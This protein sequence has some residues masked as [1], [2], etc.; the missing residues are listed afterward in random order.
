MLILNMAEKIEKLVVS[1]LKYGFVGLFV[2]TALYF[3]LGVRSLN[4]AGNS[5]EPHYSNRDSVWTIRR[6]AKYD[7]CDVVVLEG[8]KIDS[9]QDK[10]IKRIIGIPGDKIEISNGKITINGQIVNE[11]GF[12][13]TSAHDTDNISLLL[14]SNE[15]FLLG[16]NRLDSNDSR[17][18]GV[19][20][21][22]YFSK[23]LKNNGKEACLKAYIGMSEKND[24]YSTKKQLNLVLVTLIIL[25]S[26]VLVA[27]FRKYIKKIFNTK[28]L[29]TI[30]KITVSTIVLYLTILLS[31]SVLIKLLWFFKLTPAQ[32]NWGN[33]NQIINDGENQFNRYDK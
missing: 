20:G 32:N 24:L 33:V 12:I 14:R 17:G 3:L 25:I 26:T 6:F 27:T 31:L 5:M 1:V 18:F 8:E 16:D 19:L 30:A 28:T 2:L 15:Y 22:N 11:N 10:L 21:K 23:V 13:S 4:I 29:I 9:G 7:R